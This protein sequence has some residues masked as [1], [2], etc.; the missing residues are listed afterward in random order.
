[1]FMSYAHIMIL[2]RNNIDGN[3]VETLSPCGGDEKHLLKP[4]HDCDLWIE[5]PSNDP[6]NRGIL[7]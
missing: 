2:H 6:K 7:G 1:M 3:T 4:V 5:K